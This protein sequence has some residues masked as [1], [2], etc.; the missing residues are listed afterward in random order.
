MG[1]SV[2]SMWER[3]RARGRAPARARAVPVR[4]DI[5]MHHTKASLFLSRKSPAYCNFNFN[6]N[7][8]FHFHLHFQKSRVPSKER[9][10]REPL[11]AL[12]SYGA[13]ARTPSGRAFKFFKFYLF[14]FFSFSTIF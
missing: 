7:F 4:E 2:C 11:R 3:A 14:F 5:Q 6:F 8:N 9:V 10:L 12:A 13:Q 1:D